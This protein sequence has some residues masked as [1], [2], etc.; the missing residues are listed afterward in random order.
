M[1][2]VAIKLL[3]ASLKQRGFQLKAI[4][5]A[6]FL[7]LIPLSAAHS[8]EVDGLVSGMALEEAKKV[9]ERYSYSKIYVKENGIRAWDYPEK[10]THRMITLIF[11][12]DKLVH[13][14]KHLLPGFDHFVR[15]IDSKRKELGQ[16]LKSWSQPTDVALPI[17]GNTISFLWKD[18]NSIITIAYTAFEKSDQ[19]HITYEINHQC[20]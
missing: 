9:L 3:T 1:L 6:L 8:F 18:G 11:C 10:N 20:W 14:Q 15:L 17:N 12:K 2:T 19:L 13:L 4:A 16:P 5:I 7:T